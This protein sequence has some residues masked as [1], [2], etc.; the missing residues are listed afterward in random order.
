[1]CLL[2]AFATENSHSA[3][4]WGW[5]VMARAVAATPPLAL[6]VIAKTNRRRLQGVGGAEAGVMAAIG[7]GGGGEEALQ[8]QR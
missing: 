8:R 3:R 5:S 4:S 7:G 6:D 1:M 2:E